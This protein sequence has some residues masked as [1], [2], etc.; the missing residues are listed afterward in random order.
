MDAGI[1]V[2][3]AATGCKPSTGGSG[4]VK[5]GTSNKPPTASSSGRVPPKR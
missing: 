3:A 1:K 4:V 2:K 5:S